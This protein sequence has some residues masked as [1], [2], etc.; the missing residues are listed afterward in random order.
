MVG[1]DQWTPAAVQ[2]HVAVD[3]PSAWLPL[4]RGPGGG[5]SFRYPFVEC[6]RDVLVGVVPE[7]NHRSR[8]ACERL[9]FRLAHTVEG[10]FAP[11]C[12]LL[13]YEMRRAECRYLGG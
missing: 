13:L 4:L 7:D 12:D 11:G 1:Y 10:G 9:G 2:C 8:R 5:P 3:T 6:G